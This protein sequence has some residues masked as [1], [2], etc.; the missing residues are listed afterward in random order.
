VSAP[1]SST[2]TGLE[3]TFL[4]MLVTLAAAGWMLLRARKT[5]PSDVATAAASEPDATRVRLPAR[6]Q[7]AHR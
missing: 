1:N 2:S 7:P 3:V 5:F 6:R 4:V